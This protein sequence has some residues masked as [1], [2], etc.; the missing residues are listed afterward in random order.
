MNRS[1][2]AIGLIVVVMTGLASGR[3]D[4]V[5]AQGRSITSRDGT[6]HLVPVDFS[7]IQDAINGAADL[8]TIVVLSGTYQENIDFLGKAITVRSQMGASMTTIDGGQAGSVVTFSNGEGPDSVLDGFSIVN[9]TGTVGPWSYLQGGGIYCSSSSPLIR[10]NT[11]LDNTATTGGGIYCNDSSPEISCNTIRNNA[12]YKGGGIY[13]ADLSSPFLL[14][15]MIVNNDASS[16][17]GGICCWNQG[18]AVIT[19]NTFSGNSCLKEGGGIYAVRYSSV[20]VAN[21]ILWNDAAPDGPEIWLGG[22]THTS[23]LSIS[24]SNVM[25]GLELVHVDTGCVLEWGNGMIDIDPQFVDPDADDFHLADGSPCE[26][27]GDSSVPYLPMIDFEGDRRIGSEIVDIGADE[28]YNGTTIRVPNH[29]PTIQEAIDASYNKDIVYVSS[30]YYAENIV[31]NG[32]KIT[33]ESVNGPSATSL[34]GNQAGSVVTFNAFEG[35]ETVLKGFTITNGNTNAGAGILCDLSCPTITENIITTNTSSGWGGGICCRTRA[36]PVIEKNTLTNNSAF[37]GGAIACR[38]SSPEIRNNDITGNGLTA[39]GGGIWCGDGSTPVI[40][41]NTI[42][43]NQNTGI[44]CDSSAPTIMGNRI[45]TNSSFSSAGGIGLLD[46][47][48]VIVCNIINGNAALYGGG[49]YC[50]GSDAA[51]TNN[52]IRSNWAFSVGGGLYCSDSSPIVTNT[53]FWEDLAPSGTEIA[54]LSGSPSITYCDVEGGWTGTGNI[55]VDPLFISASDEDYHLLY[56]SPCKEAGSHTAPQLPTYDFE[57]DPRIHDGAVDIGADEFH[58]HLYHRDPVVPGDQLLIIN[59]GLPYV[60]PLTLCLG[61][62]IEDPPIS[63]QY[64]DLWLVMPFVTT[65]PMNSIQYNGFSETLIDIPGSWHS[66][67]EYPFQSFALAP[68]HP[69]ARLSNL[70]VLVVD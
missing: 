64:G 70:M 24:H 35:P 52:T 61:A 69:Q 68:G 30:G 40:E 4:D 6:I 17:G 45:S 36:A 33:V 5:G 3:S 31:F 10:N 53:I 11:I 14:N 41:G 26:E 46:S 9:G 42:S 8:D 57:G 21:T 50:S 44:M 2:A 34:D 28:I 47:D 27:A 43:G 16:H 62:G 13:A 66:G 56:L 49:I 32:R 25:N 18:N 63:T 59:V 19:N 38:D 23:S 1:I 54:V 48:A 29:Y 39:F 20:V 37:Q 60:S 15:N 7:T 55:D 67:E 65:I 12:A 58:F 51:I 22:P